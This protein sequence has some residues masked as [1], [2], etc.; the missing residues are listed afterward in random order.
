MENCNIVHEVSLENNDQSP[1]VCSERS[2]EVS[3]S[4]NS[5]AKRELAGELLAQGITEEAVC[6]ILHI[7]AAELPKHDSF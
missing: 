3:V 2:G 7:S 4:G 6:R 5:A 1:V